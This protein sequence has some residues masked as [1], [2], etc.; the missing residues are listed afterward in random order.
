ML[1]SRGFKVK[2]GGE[3]KK[4]KNERED[5]ESI[6]RYQTVRNPVRSVQGARERKN[7][8]PITAREAR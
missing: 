4:E 1:R 6:G 5:P 8:P 2:W 7:R 3:K